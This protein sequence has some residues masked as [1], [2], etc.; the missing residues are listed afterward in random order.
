MTRPAY[1]MH[2]DKNFNFLKD[3]SF[4]LSLLLLMGLLTYANK[5]YYYERDR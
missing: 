3:R 2:Y 5:K 4:F 1:P